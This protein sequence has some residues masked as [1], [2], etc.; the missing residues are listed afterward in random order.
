MQSQASIWKVDRRRQVFS[1][2]L[3]V[4]E[5]AY[6][7]TSC[8]TEVFLHRMGDGRAINTSDPLTHSL[9]HSLESSPV[10]SPAG[11]RMLRGTPL[12]T[13]AA[14][15]GNSSGH[16]G[17]DDATATDA[18]GGSELSIRPRKHRDSRWRLSH[19]FGLC[20]CCL[21]WIQR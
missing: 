6:T 21:R 17:L 8:L 4:H 18:D 20:I 12:C 10:I 5:R 16:T 1:R 15:A 14:H 11:I 19:R 13:S 3:T 9:P 2:G 7:H